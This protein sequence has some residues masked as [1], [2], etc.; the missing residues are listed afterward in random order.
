MRLIVQDLKMLLKR[1]GYQESFSHYS[2]GGGPL[3]NMKML[4]FLTQLLYYEI[5]QT[6]SSLNTVHAAINTFIQA[7]F[8]S[9]NRPQL[10]PKLDKE[11][12]LSQEEE[13]KETDAIPFESDDFS[14]V[15]TL[16]F[17]FFNLQQWQANKQHFIRILISIAIQMNQH[18]IQTKVKRKKDEPVP[19][20]LLLKKIS[21]RNS[22]YFYF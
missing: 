17:A 12:K 14:Y 10:N 20:T 2:Q 9:S 11:G 7:I 18:G 4:P 16:V 8:S 13:K 6:P 1:F 22:L 5:I 15:I 19:P 3:H 21:Q